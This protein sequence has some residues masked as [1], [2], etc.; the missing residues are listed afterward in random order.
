MS[1]LTSIQTLIM[2]DHPLIT[3]YIGYF[4]L[5]EGKLVLRKGKKHSVV[6]RFSANKEY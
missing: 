4:I 1:M 2:H 3:L 6:A 5:L